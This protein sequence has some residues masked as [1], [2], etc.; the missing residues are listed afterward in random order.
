M[1]GLLNRFRRGSSSAQV[2]EDKKSKSNSKTTNNNSITTDSLKPVTSKGS[3]KTSNKQP[4]NQNLISISL[5][6]KESKRNSNKKYDN[7]EKGS[8]LTKTN[9]LNEKKSDLNVFGLIID[10]VA[11]NSGQPIPEN[12]IIQIFDPEPAPEEIRETN[13]CDQITFIDDR[14]FIFDDEEVSVEKLDD[15]AKE[16]NCVT[17]NEV[18]E[19][20]LSKFS[21][22]SSRASSRNSSIGSESTRSSCNI[23]DRDDSDNLSN[24]ASKPLSKENSVDS[25]N[26][27]QNGSK[28]VLLDA[29]IKKFNVSMDIETVSNPEKKSDTPDNLSETSGHKPSSLIKKQPIKYHGEDHKRKQRSE[30]QRKIN[31]SNMNKN[32]SIADSMTEIGID[33]TSS[34]DDDPKQIKLVKS[35]STQV[36][37]TLN[38]RNKYHRTISVTRLPQNF[39]CKYIGKTRCTG[40][41]GLKHIRD[42][43][44]YLVTTSRQ[45]RSLD[46]LPDV[47]AL[48]SEK[49]I[50]IVQKSK[51]DKENRLTDAFKNIT[52]T[53]EP[54]TS[55]NTIQIE[56]NQTNQ[57]AINRKESILTSK[58]GQAVTG[59]KH[60]Q[61]G[62]LP[63]SNISYA[64]QDNVY[65][66][67][68]SC[69]IVRECE[70]KT[71][72]ECYS[73]LCK[74]MESARRMALSI[75]LAFKEYGKLLQLKETRINRKIAIHGGSNEKN[76]DS[77][78]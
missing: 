74:Q 17:I 69:I 46:E 36:T 35:S 68:F 62:L 37:R 51:S 22:K 32:S 20:R 8:K 41:W 18:P 65:S 54:T 72:S 38:K 26:K 70:G 55:A 21:S 19:D 76:G 58:E 50:Y 4:K 2:N 6:S 71:I 14:N 56:K 47:E 16:N 28:N 53:N 40:L 59:E 15:L 25:E 7:A 66:K 29:L 67:V 45:L 42:P 9:D 60:Y 3:Q 43:V 61:S 34:F 24:N 63:I 49:G 11:D 78:A 30:L 39:E 1:N 27:M 77:F 12:S 57:A 23:L 44:D 5:Q 73:F 48:I 31:R 13:R 33:A 52:Q 75:T 64:V 10:P